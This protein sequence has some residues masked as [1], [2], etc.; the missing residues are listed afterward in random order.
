LPLCLIKHY[1]IDDV[2]GSGGIAL[3]FLTSA[4]Y[5]GER[6]ASGPGPF[7]PGDKVPGTH[8]VGGSV[9]LR[10]GIDAEK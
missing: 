8:W 2:W 9:G 7:N 3:P 5:G 10:A 6:S 4:L 1:A